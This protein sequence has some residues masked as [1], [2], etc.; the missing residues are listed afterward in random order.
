MGIIS[1]FYA[2]NADFAIKNSERKQLQTSFNTKN[3]YMLHKP[4]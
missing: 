3:V 4:V 2:T 1:L